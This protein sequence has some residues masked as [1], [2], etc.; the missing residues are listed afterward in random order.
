MEQVRPLKVKAQNWYL[1]TICPKVSHQTKSK[2]Q[3]WESTHSS[4]EEVCTREDR[5][6]FSSLNLPTRLLKSG[7]I[8][9]PLVPTE[10]FAPSN[11]PNRLC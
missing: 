5:D 10:R 1:V 2:V 8:P 7:L 6:D 4:H 11:V 9:S 3:G